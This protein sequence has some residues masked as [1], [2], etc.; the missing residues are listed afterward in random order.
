[1]RLAAGSLL[2]KFACIEAHR[3]F[4]QPADLD[5]LAMLIQDPVVEVRTKFLEIVIASLSTDDLPPHYII[6]LPI[7]AF[8]PDDE[9][10]AN[11]K[12]YIARKLKQQ[13]SSSETED[14]V[15][16]SIVRLIHLLSHHPDFDNDVATVKSFETYLDF[17][18]DLVCT[19]IN[20][21]Y[22]YRAAGELKV[23]KD[24]FTES[25]DP[26]Y[27]IGELAQLSIQRRCATH[28]W[29]LQTY[30]GHIAFS[31][32]LFERLPRDEAAKVT[33]TSYL[34][35]SFYEKKKAEPRHSLAA[36]HGTSTKSRIRKDRNVVDSDENGNYEPPSSPQSK[37]ATS[38]GTRSKRVL[39]EKQVG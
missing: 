36:S 2:V 1:M 4:L 3:Y 9:M 31:K 14:L 6:L 39:G 24:K 21:S 5:L 30:S 38:R 7:V 8:D 15:E 13:Q 32:E 18:L 22:L 19:S 26:L 35:A 33:K 20:V 17:Y 25:S 23:V 16:H 37:N 12:S 28:G 29:L 11:A 10:V 34:H 27:V